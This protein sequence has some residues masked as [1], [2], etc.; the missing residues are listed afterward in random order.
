MK[1]PSRAE[2]PLPTSYR[3]EMDV[4]PLLD[5]DDANYY[6]SLIGILRWTVEIGRIDITTETSMLAAHLAMPRHGHLLA[7]IRVFA[8]LKKKHNARIVFDPTYP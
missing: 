3:P 4:S 8:Y 6:Q 1:L 2:T 7:A 5:P